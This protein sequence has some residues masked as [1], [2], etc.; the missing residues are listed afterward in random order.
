MP[1][2]WLIRKGF[3]DSAYLSMI[4]SIVKL[5]YEYTLIDTIPFS[6]EYTVDH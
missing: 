1:K 2:H 3:N 5:G 6:K 4:E